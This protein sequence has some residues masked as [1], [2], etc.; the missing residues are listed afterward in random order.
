MQQMPSPASLWN[1]HEGLSQLWSRCSSASEVL[2]GLRCRTASNL[3]NRESQRSNGH[4]VD[5]EGQVNQGPYNTALQQRL[6]EQQRRR[7]LLTSSQPVQLSIRDKQA[8]HRVQGPDSPIIS[9]RG[10]REHLW[11]PLPDGEPEH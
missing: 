9:R 11:C 1:R 2:Q 5:Q 3:E 4:L 10:Q 6:S 8:L 7:S